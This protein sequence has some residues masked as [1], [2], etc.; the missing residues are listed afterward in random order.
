MRALAVGCM[1]LYHAFFLLPI[2]RSWAYPW[3]LRFD[4]SVQVFFVLSGFLIYGPYGRAH[5]RGTPAPTL[6]RYALRRF[7]RIYPAYWLTLGTM[8]VLGWVRFS[9]GAEALQ[10]ATLTQSWF[11]RED[12]H[13][14]FSAGLGQA[15]TL[16]VEVA[17]Y[18]FV[19]IWAWAMRSLAAAGRVAPF[20]QEVLGVG[21]LLAVGAVSAALVADHALPSQF[22]IL[23]AHLTSL[24]WGMLLALMVARRQQRQQERAPGGPEPDWVTAPGGSVSLDVSADLA[25][26]LPRRSRLAAVLRRSAT[27]V[28]WLVAWLVLALGC[29]RLDE[30]SAEAGHVRLQHAV[31]ATAAAL[32]VT[33]VV[34]GA[35]GRGWVRRLLTWRPV[36]FV[37]V[38]SYGVYLWHL[39]LFIDLPGPWRDA[40]TGPALLGMAAKIGIALLAGVASWFLLEQPLMRW[41]DRRTRGAPDTTPAELTPAP[42]PT[43]TS[44]V[45]PGPTSPALGGDPAP[46]P[47]VALGTGTEP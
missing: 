10:H 5:L 9:D 1:V 32:L 30:V 12:T 36:V 43:P 17:F 13:F 3:L 40:P 6:G 35:P 21:V 31:N 24:G 7:A 2:T 28:S 18:A 33:P 34:L 25:E 38:V 14:V 8:A 42:T 20:H 41:A 19:P 11:P 4:V 47:G 37:G 44:T 39:D 22:A 27:E 26:A 15:W 46:R 29:L 16:V 23:P 45:A